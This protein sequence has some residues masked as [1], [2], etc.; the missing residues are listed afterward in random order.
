[1]AIIVYPELY[2]TYIL[3]LVLLSNL[4][5]YHSL[6]FWSPPSNLS[7]METQLCPVIFSSRVTLKVIS[8]QHTL[9]PTKAHCQIT[10]DRLVWMQ[11]QR[12]NT[13]LSRL[14]SWNPSVVLERAFLRVLR[15]CHR[16]ISY[17]YANSRLYRCYIWRKSVRLSQAIIWC[18][19][20][21]LRDTAVWRPW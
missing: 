10:I 6:Q 15:S 1:M 19:R 18:S 2:R 14:L 4:K 16:R 11:W 3:T 17:I 20:I 12:P 9:S 21:K 8:A 13:S 7:N 5:E